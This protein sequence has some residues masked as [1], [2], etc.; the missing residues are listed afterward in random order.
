MA[1]H[2]GR[3]IY[4]LH[5]TSK[6]HSADPFF[7]LYEEKHGHSWEWENH[8]DF[9]PRL[10]DPLVSSILHKRHSINVHGATSHSIYKHLWVTIWRPRPIRLFA[11]KRVLL[12]D[13]SAKGGP[14]Y[15][16]GWRSAV[17]LLQ[18]FYTTKVI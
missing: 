10:I 6:S 15:I 14:L 4:P 16:H 13:V 1:A 18:I 12:Y 9:L 8:Q 2:T 5:T 3:S 11:L 17:V 7:R